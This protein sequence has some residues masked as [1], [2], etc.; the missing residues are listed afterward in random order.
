MAE[1]WMNNPEAFYKWLERKNDEGQMHR[2]A[3]IATREITSAL[4][5]SSALDKRGIEPEPRSDYTLSGR[6]LAVRE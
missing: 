6:F 4:Y 2:H 1:T 3:E 5:K